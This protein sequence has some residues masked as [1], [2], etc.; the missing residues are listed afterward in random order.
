MDRYTCFPDVF[1]AICRYDNEGM[2][3]EIIDT[4]VDEEVAQEQIMAYAFEEAYESAMQALQSH[5]MTMARVI[6]QVRLDCPRYFYKKVDLRKSF[7]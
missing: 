7:E 1:Y 6:Y 5:D 4:T 3:F 2:D